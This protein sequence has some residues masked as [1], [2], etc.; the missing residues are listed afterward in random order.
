[1]SSYNRLFDSNLK[2]S[3]LSYL[4]FKNIKDVPED[5]FNQF[6]EAYNKAYNIAEARECAEAKK[7][8]LG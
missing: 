6:R 4:Y 7:G 5:E 8:I 2:T 3:S 1:M